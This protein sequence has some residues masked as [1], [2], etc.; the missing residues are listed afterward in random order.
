MRRQQRDNFKRMYTL[1]LMT[2]G[3]SGL[4]III[5]TLVIFYSAIDANRR[6][7]IAYQPVSNKPASEEA[8]IKYGEELVNHTSRYLGPNGEIKSVSNGMNCT[9]CHLD[10][11][12][13]MFGINYAG[14]AANYPKYRNRSGTVVT[15]KER[16]NECFQRSLNGTGLDSNDYELKAMAAYIISIGKGVSR[17]TTPYGTGLKSLPF[18]SRLANSEKGE[19]VYRDQCAQC[20]GSNGEGKRDGSGME[21]KYPPL[22]GD[23]SYNIGAGLYRLSR[24][25]SFVKYNMPYGVTYENPVLTDEE[26]WDVAAFINSMPRPSKDI[27]NDWPDIS[28]KPIDYPFGPYAD[29]LT[30]EQ[31]KFG[32]WLISLSY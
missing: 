31:H 14:V 28:K 20:H 10:G 13:K 19:N 16:I 9:N 2:I 6:L 26:A 22:Y 21:W 17:K 32:P 3:C 29:N 23:H 18:L 27:S 25:A 1:I 11:G 12:R 24:F 8:F 7:T 4:A 5:F 30:D 15:I